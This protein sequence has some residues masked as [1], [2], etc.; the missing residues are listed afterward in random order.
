MKIVSVIFK[1]GSFLWFLSASFGGSPRAQT[2]MLTLENCIDAAI[3]NSLQAKMTAQSSIKSEL[4]FKTAIKVFYPS[5]SIDI[6]PVYY[7]RSFVRRYDFENNIEVFREQQNLFSSARLQMV[8]EI[9]PTGG[10]I[11]I[12]SEINRFENLSESENAIFNGVPVGI[13]YNQ[14]LSLFNKGKADLKLAR[15]VYEYE[16]VFLKSELIE[17]KQK[18]TELFFTTAQAELRYQIAK[19]NL[20]TFD[21]M[22]TRTLALYYNAGVTKQR[23]LQLELAKMNADNQAKID[24]L[25]AIVTKRQLLN[26][27]HMDYTDEVR[28]DYFHISDSTIPGQ[29]QQ[30]AMIMLAQIKAQH[31]EIKLK[32]AKAERLSNANIFIDAGFNQTSSEWKEVYYNYLPKQMVQMGIQIPLVDFG[33]AKIAYEIALAEYNYANLELE[34]KMKDAELKTMELTE[35]LLLTNHLIVQ[36]NKAVELLKISVELTKNSYI[37]GSAQLFELQNS[38]NEQMHTELLHLTYL[39]QY[40]MLLLELEK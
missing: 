38:L 12:Y 11:K 16:K 29:A 18:A 28:L 22:Y 3:A 19:R 1:I 30:N 39:Q 23:L 4:T 14:P 27:L 34:I 2:T 33:R 35:Q 37:N 24:S 7:D 36:T 9:I 8:Q 26:F 25:A 10:S 20:A 21:T 31:A 13:Q 40:R 5:I 6:T 15:S 32:M 17:I